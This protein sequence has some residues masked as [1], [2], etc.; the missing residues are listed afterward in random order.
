MCVIYYYY[1][2]CL[3][4]CCLLTLL[5]IDCENYLKKTCMISLFRFPSKSCQ[6]RDVTITLDRTRHQV[7][8][9][10][11]VVTRLVIDAGCII[12]CYGDILPCGP[13]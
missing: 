1:Y 7:R 8:P 6:K 5:V 2:Y 13:S 10:L 3:L 11:L 9:C 12:L 4:T